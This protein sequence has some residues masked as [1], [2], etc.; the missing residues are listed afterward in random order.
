MRSKTPE[1]P[2]KTKGKHDT[3]KGIGN[4]PMLGITLWLE[5]LSFLAEVN[6]TT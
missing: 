3:D 5:Y 1:K 2:L 4:Y 6:K